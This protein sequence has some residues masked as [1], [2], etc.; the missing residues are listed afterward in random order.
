MAL[1][2]SDPDCVSALQVV[3]TTESVCKLLSSQKLHSII[4]LIAKIS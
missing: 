3:L 4:V 2:P 1:E